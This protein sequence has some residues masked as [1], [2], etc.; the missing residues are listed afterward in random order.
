MRIE[1][2]SSLKDLVTTVEY[3]TLQKLNYVFAY[4][5]AACKVRPPP[6]GIPSINT[7]GY[8]YFHT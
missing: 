7:L 1:G 2:Y 8:Y 5:L 6:S 3:L 4:S